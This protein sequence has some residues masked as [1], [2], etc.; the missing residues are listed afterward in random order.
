MKRPRKVTAPALY[1]KEYIRCS[2]QMIIRRSKDTDK[3]TR[4]KKKGKDSK[5]IETEKGRRRQTKQSL[6]KHI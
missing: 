4:N 3:A 2:Q 5:K 1:P 6:I